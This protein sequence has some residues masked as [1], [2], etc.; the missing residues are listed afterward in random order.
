MR[1]G[2][3]RLHPDVARS[4]VDLRVDGRYLARHGL[5]GQRIGGHPYDES[6]MHERELLLRQ[7]KIDENRIQRLQRDDWL[8]F[9]DDLAQVDLADAQPAGERRTDGFLRDHG[10]DV[11]RLGDGLFVARLGVVE[12]RLRDGP[13]GEQFGQALQVQFGQHHRSLGRPQLGFFRRSVLL[14]Q[15]L[16]GFNQRARFEVDLHD[17]S[18]QLGRHGHPLDRRQRTDRGQH[19]LPVLQR[20]PRRGHG[21]GRRHIL[22]AMG[23]HAVDLQALDAAEDRSQDRHRRQCQ[24]ESLFHKALTINVCIR[25]CAAVPCAF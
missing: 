12:L 3:R 8:A 11:V 18:A 25:F 6:R 17:L 4:R 16:P 14:H 9:V 7:C 20:C 2:H 24:D 21:L 13:L 15:E 22:R 1:I 10:A 23:D 5:A 19:R